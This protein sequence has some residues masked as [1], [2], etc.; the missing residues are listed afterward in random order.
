MMQFDNYLEHHGILGMKWGKRN[1]PPYPLGSDDHSASEKKAGWRKSLKSKVGGIRRA[2]KRAEARGIR[3]TSK[4]YQN[5]YGLSKADADEAARKKRALMKKVAIG[6]GIAVGVAAT[7]YV[8]S[9]LGRNYCDDLIKAGTTIQTLSSDPDRLNN[10]KAFFTAHRKADMKAY[11]GGFGQ[12]NTI[13]GTPVAGTNKYKLQAV[14]ENN[15]RVAG[16]HNANKVF[17]E[18]MNNNKEFKDAVLKDYHFNPGLGETRFEQFN[19]H[20]ALDGPSAKAPKMFFEELKK[21]GYGAVA[22]VNDRKFSGYNTHASIVF[23]N[24]GF[25]QDRSGK[26]AYKLVEKLTDEEINKGREYF[27]RHV[28][29]GLIINNPHIVAAGS[30]YVG[31]MISGLYDDSVNH[32]NRE[33]QDLINKDRR[34]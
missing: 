21:R 5:E 8:V 1:G 19:K 32:R 29:A 33:K 3:E 20:F 15:I 34:R 30:A 31:A 9:N 28:T 2:A 25:K 18:L 22:D 23:D 4:K 24:S 17:N 26:I 11:V 7:A 14:A 13:F 10:G 6:A 12:K 27:N 16:S